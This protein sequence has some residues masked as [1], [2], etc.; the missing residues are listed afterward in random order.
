MIYVDCD[1]VIAESTS[2]YIDIIDR[3]FGIKRTFEDIS[4]FDLKVSFGMTQEQFNHFFEVVHSRAEI[5]KFK[6]IEGAIETLTEWM[7]QGHEVS[8]ITGRITDAYT[9]TLDWLAMY[10]VPY[11]HFCIVDKYSRPEMDTSIAK[12]LEFLHSIDIDFAVEDSLT[13]AKYLADKLGVPVAL[14]DRP[15]NQG[16]SLNPLITRVSNW[17][18]VKRVFAEKVNRN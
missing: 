3:E 4:S 14:I 15:W 16:N 5:M 11:N 18:D 1:D 10:K 12:P 17:S 2:A 9:S 13:M 8:I 6:P 7:S